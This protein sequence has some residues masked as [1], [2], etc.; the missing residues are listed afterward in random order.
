LSAA[1]ITGR[2]E[3][4]ETLLAV[5][6]R[7]CLPTFPLGYAWH[8]VTF[9]D[10]Y[11]RLDLYRAEVII[12]FGMASMLVQA[13]IFA[14]MYPRLFSTRREDWMASALRFAGVFA[15]LAWSF[16]TL[17]VA[18]K[19]Q[20]SSVAAFMMLETGFTLVQFA[21]IA[22]LIALAQRG[23]QASHTATVVPG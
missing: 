1:C 4:E 16:T 10:A 20:M 23:T 9:K 14:W 3:H 17:P 7:I 13:V 19:Y 18:A 12:P 22:P 8:L 6:A 15:P 21:I 2:A 11:D 5:G